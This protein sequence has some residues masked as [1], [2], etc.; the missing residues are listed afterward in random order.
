M[1][2]ANHSETDG[3]QGWLSWA[4]TVPLCACGFVGLAALY[5]AISIS[6]RRHLDRHSFHLA[7]ILREWVARYHI[8]PSSPLLEH[9]KYERCI[10]P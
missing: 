5:L 6:F 9:I 3:G 10:K 1:A 4:V 8:P 7:H 2:N